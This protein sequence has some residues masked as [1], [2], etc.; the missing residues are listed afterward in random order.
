MCQSSQLNIVVILWQILPVRCKQMR[1]APLSQ[2]TYIGKRCVQLS[3]TKLKRIRKLDI[4]FKRRKGQKL[5]SGA[6]CRLRSTMK[7]TD[8]QSMVM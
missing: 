6:Y 8:S 7:M 1:E 3:C 5:S 4:G 2:R